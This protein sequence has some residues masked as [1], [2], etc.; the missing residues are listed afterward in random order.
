MARRRFGCNSRSPL[1][2]THDGYPKLP[3]P[4]VDYQ[5]SRSLSLAG[6]GGRADRSF[7]EQL[8]DID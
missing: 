5:P 6:S 7:N 3:T 4:T 2:L 1:A 8:S